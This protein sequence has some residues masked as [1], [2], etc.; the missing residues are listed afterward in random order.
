MKTGIHS[1]SLKLRLACSGLS[2]FYGWAT[3]GYARAGGTDVLSWNLK[4]KP[5]QEWNTTVTQVETN[6]FPTSRVLE[7]ENETK[8]IYLSFL[9]IFLYHMKKI[10]N[11]YLGHYFLYQTFLYVKKK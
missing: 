11:F 7:P 9:L 2:S 6:E 10:H 1:L 5:N 3:A 4:Y 8:A